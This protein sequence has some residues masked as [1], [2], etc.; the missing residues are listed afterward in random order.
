MEIVK[1][2]L[3]HI[4]LQRHS[5]LLNVRILDAAAWSLRISFKSNAIGDIKKYIFLFE[6]VAK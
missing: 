3:I 1:H 5:W 2:S 4:T 6:Y